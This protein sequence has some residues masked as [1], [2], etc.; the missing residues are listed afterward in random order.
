M[1]QLQLFLPC[2]A[3]VGLVAV[4]LPKGA[5]IAY[6][7]AWLV[8]SLALHRAWRAASPEA[9]WPA[10]AAWLASAAGLVAISWKWGETTGLSR[11]LPVAAASLLLFFVMARLPGRALALRASTAGAGWRERGQWLAVM[12]VLSVLVGIFSGGP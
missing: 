11:S 3:G 12:A 6:A 5:Y 7:G 8:S 10:W 2:A 1:N 4:F 9:A